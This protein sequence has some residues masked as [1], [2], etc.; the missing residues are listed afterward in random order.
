[1]ED[2]VV[3]DRDHGGWSRVRHIGGSATAEPVLVALDLLRQQQML[4]N[5]LVAADAVSLTAAWIIVLATGTPG[6]RL[7]ITAAAVGVTLAILATQSFYRPGA[8]RG[9]VQDVRTAVPAVVA[10]A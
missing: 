3:S 10:G 7:A 1:M 2:V 6:R 9:T 5:R 4:R 8:V